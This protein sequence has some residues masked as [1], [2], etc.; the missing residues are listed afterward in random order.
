M[1]IAFLALLA[2]GGIAYQ[3]AGPG[4]AQSQTPAPPAPATP[5]LA[6][7]V[8]RQS[9]PLRIDIIGTVQVIAS[10][11]VKSRVDG[12][13]SEVKVK[14]G[15]YVSKGDVLFQLDRRAAEA[16]VHQAQ[17]QLARD[18]AQL[19]F[20]QQDVKRYAPLTEKSYV[21]RQQFEQAQSNQA[22]L[23]AAVQADQAA[24]ENAQ[25]LLT[26]YTIASPLDGRLGMVTLKAGNNV[27]ANDVPFLF[28]NQV[29][30]I[31]VLFPVAERELPAIRAAMAKG[32]VPLAVKPQGDEGPAIEG[33]L[34]FFENTVDATT[35]TIA[36][37]GVFANEDERLWP[38]Q[39]V[40]VSM[41]LGEEEN[42]LT[43][44]QAAVQISQGN[45][46]VFV[47]RQDNTV[48]L[49]HV[50]VGRTVDGRS[51]IASGLKEGE[52]IVID[53]QLRLKDGSRVDIRSGQELAA[54]AKSS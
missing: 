44:P 52:R 4:A 24:L 6:A 47:V 46:Y 3:V 2:A 10:V 27:K 28:I 5:E 53:G 43:V 20:A 15:Q 30:P 54:P 50:T 1:T 29:K 21:S 11:A 31:Y 7:Q 33:R 16:Q 45:P 35:G 40:N 37:R 39:F 9:V 49:R 42:A 22:A 51:V 41:R 13:I 38:G 36:L 14:D 8:E 17:G 19:V 23:E 18:K 32:P 25:V 48:A 34:A 12:Q 26:Y